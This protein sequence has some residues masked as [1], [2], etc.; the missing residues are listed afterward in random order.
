MLTENLSRLMLGTVQLGMPYG[1]ANRTGR[2]S[3]EQA[4][5]IIACA[6]EGGINCLDTAIAYGNSEEV[7]GRVLGEL[8]LRDEFTIVTKL[9][10]LGEV[11]PDPA[12][13]RRRMEEQLR[14]SLARLGLDRLPV[15]LFHREEDFR[16]V[17]A[18]LALRDRGLVERVGCSV[19]TPGV[20]E[21]IIAGGKAQALQVPTNLLDHRFTGAG[22]LQA[23]AAQGIA[24]FVRSVYLQG[25]VL[26][27][28]GNIPPELAVVIPVRRRLE[29]LAAE[30]G[31]TAAELALRYALTL[32]GVTSV[33]VGVETVEQMQDNIELCN[34][35]SLE[36][37]LV[38]AVKAAVPDLGDDI[39][40]P[41]RWPNA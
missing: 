26:M 30:A 7:I 40:M 28:E 9:P 13:L 4:R 34:R 18:L 25:L 29:R 14:G 27:L 36:A 3:Y 22:L 23:A 39:L 21:G 41:N 19:M 11:E 1:I 10:A 12:A 5:D 17:E 20:T 32:P 15:C 24:V 2:P 6:H 31:I 33:V 16:A 38:E 37:S 8:G 35:G